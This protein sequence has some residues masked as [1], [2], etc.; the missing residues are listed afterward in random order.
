MKEILFTLNGEECRVP[1]R[2]GE[3]VLET[4]RTRC[5]SYSTKDGC[6]P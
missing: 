4:L 2:A 3:S 6:Q 1:V 5:G